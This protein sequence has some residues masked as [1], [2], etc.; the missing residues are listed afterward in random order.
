MNCPLCEPTFEAFLTYQM[1]DKQEEDEATRQG[2][3]GTVDGIEQ[4]LQKRLLSEWAGERTSAIGRVTEKWIRLKLFSN[5]RFDSVEIQTWKDR[6]LKRAAE[7][8]EEL[9][10]L[11]TSTEHYKEW[12]L[13]TGCGACNG[14]KFAALGWE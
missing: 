6:I 13:Y 4:K 12:S 9:M 10:K 5:N 7:G 11:I 2:E 8:K 3:R 1:R 14:A